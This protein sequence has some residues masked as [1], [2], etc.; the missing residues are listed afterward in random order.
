M[1]IVINSLGYVHPDGETL[2]DNIS[3]ALQK[4]EKASLIG[5]N[6]S[7][8]ST[9]LKIV[10]GCLASARG[11]VVLPERPYYIPQHLGQYDS[12][13]V[14]EALQVKEKADALHAI[15]SGEV[16][17]ENLRVLNDD[18]EIEERVQAALSHWGMQGLDTA[19]RMCL[20]SGGEKTK[21]FL[22]GIRI[23]L[24]G[25]VLLD[26]PTNHLDFKSRAVLYEFILR[27]RGTQL[28]VSH[29]RELLNLMD[30]T[31]ELG[32][33]GVESYGGNYD[34]YHSQREAK[35]QALQTQLDEK[36]RNLKQARQ[37]ARDMAEQRQR[38]ES[39][40][41]TQKEKAGIPRIAM[42]G[43]KNRAERSTAKL[44]SEQS[45]KMEDIAEDMRQLKQQIQARQA[46]KFD[47]K[48]SGLHR[49]KVLVKA[50]EVNVCYGERVLW[51][52]PLSF[53]IDSG[54][55]WRIRGD[56]GSGK[57]SLV[58]LIAG[59]LEP[60]AGR[61]F[62]AD[63]RHLYVDQEYSIIDNGLTV[64]GQAVA[65]ND[66]LLPEHDLKMLL[67]YHRFTG[68]YWERP[69]AS[70]SGGE[71]MR[72]LLCCL[73]ISN[74]APDLL[75]LDEPTNNLDVHS[76]EVLTETIRSFEGTLLLI[77]HDRVFIDKVG[78]D[79]SLEL[80]GGLSIGEG[81]IS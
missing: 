35:T 20:L 38:L 74:N 66:R 50:E 80:D 8:K 11:E 21:V 53:Q 77:S 70:L 2:F 65:F 61:L 9:L 45:D 39:R 3:F 76:Q 54:D 55:R 49:G 27:Y 29:D 5:N 37:K 56:N 69:C 67:H 31:L 6:G 64:F 59:D 36:E 78:A 46:L 52:E 24:P 26:E 58:R 42:G 12:F 15:L 43:L 19:S 28:I 30:K 73:A 79:K 62:V 1:S 68:D 18:W 23:H 14:L 57:T 44:N 7:G 10:S 16:S 34:F 17:E 41:K 33:H 81:L 60:S 47:I 40:G 4:G 51:K 22:A 75:V 71:K 13:T 25:I 48:A 63:F 32:R 72:L